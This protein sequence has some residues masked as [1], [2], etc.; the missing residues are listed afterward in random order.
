[1][2]KLLDTCCCCHTVY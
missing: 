2:Y 1:M